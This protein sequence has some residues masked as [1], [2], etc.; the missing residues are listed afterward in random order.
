MSIGT[1]TTAMQRIRSARPDSPISV[2]VVEVGK[3][4]VKELDIVFGNTVEAVR[5]KLEVHAPKKPDKGQANH[6]HEWVGDFHWLQPSKAVR[7]LLK[8]ALGIK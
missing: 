3:N 6:V 7:A 1:V 4:N 5:R 2:F 8:A